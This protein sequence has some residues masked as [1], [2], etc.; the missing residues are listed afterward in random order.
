MA[1]K[2]V[3][4]KTRFCEHCGEKLLFEFV[5]AEK[6]YFGY[7]ESYPNPPYNAKTGYRN[8]IPHYWCPKKKKWFNKHDD[9]LVDEIILFSRLKVED[10]RKP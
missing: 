9:Y 4:A 7:S 6:Y 3:E 8:L 1:T 2:Y 10:R 5:G